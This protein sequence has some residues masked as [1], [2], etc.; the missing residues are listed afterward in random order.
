MMD[1]YKTF[2]CINIKVRILSQFMDLMKCIKSNDLHEMK[3]VLKKSYKWK[4][5]MW[6]WPAYSRKDSIFLHRGQPYS[7]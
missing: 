5:K 3:S 7:Q 6:S 4:L 2:I 1:N